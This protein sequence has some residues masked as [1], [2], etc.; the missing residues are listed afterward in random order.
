LR[1]LLIEDLSFADHARRIE[2]GNFELSIWM[3]IV[4][5]HSDVVMLWHT[6]V[7]ARMKNA[8]VGPYGFLETLPDREIAR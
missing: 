3:P 8:W 7:D 6:I 2:D 5:P 4:W 1:R